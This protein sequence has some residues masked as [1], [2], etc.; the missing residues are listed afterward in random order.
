MNELIV[1][2]PL[3]RASAERL[4][5]LE[6][7]KGFTLVAEAQW[8]ERSD[9]REIVASQDGKRIRLV[10][11]DALHPG[12]GAFTRLIAGIW[13]CDLM[14]VLVEP[15]QSLIDWCYRHDFRARIIGKGPD[16][17]EVWYPRKGH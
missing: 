2:G 1:R 6:V 4:R 17:H 11:L 9:W 8:L 13:R 7:S 12:K 15:N 14:P 5:Q 16:R 3:A 10:L